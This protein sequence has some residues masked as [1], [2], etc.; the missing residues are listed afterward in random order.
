[1]PELD[2]PIL[3]DDLASLEPLVAHLIF[4]LVKILNKGITHMKQ[5]ILLHLHPSQVPPF[6]WSHAELGG[7]REFLVKEACAGRFT[8]CPGLPL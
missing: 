5:T 7:L 2:M 6:D 1:M 3:M 8:P 4:K